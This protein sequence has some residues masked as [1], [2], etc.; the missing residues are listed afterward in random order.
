M[1]WNEVRAAELSARLG[2]TFRDANLL[3]HALTHSSYVNEHGGSY[4]DNNERLEFLGD[5]FFDAVIAEELYMRLGQQE[6]GVLSRIRSKVVCEQSLLRK[7]EEISLPDYLFIGRGEEKMLQ[8]RKSRSIV[9]DA[10]EAVLGAVFL[11]GGYEAVK[12]VAGTLFRDILEEA[13]SGRLEQDYKTL[14]HEKMQ[15][16]GMQPP[17]YRIIGEEGPDHDKTFFAV[18][19]ADGR[20]IGEGSGK[21]KK[22]AEQYAAK[23]ALETVSLTE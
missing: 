8:S 21:T 6:E 7:A 3:R 18:L 5:A 14:I 2:Y 4:R 16:G 23:Q 1:E 10:M 15:A 9:A 19:E 17:Q 12:K 11:D 13:L 22:Q 20:I